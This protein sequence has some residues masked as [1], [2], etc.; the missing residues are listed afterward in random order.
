MKRSTIM[1]K[2]PDEATVDHVYNAGLNMLSEFNDGEKL[3]Y[4]IKRM[5]AAGR[6]CGVTMIGMGPLYV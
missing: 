5:E 2:P 4:M 3:N 6:R 1:S